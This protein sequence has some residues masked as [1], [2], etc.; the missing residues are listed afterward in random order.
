PET[1]LEIPQKR[2][3]TR[4]EGRAYSPRSTSH[5]TNASPPAPPPAPPTFPHRTSPPQSRCIAE[6]SPVVHDGVRPPTTID[7][8]QPRSRGFH[9]AEAGRE[10]LKQGLE[11]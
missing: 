5:E 1:G 8:S 6:F 9:R 10:A 3:S 11:I 7:S 2:P 4:P